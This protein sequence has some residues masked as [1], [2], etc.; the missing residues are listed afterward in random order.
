MPLMLLTQA[1]LE[2]GKSS[3]GSWSAKQLA[4]F[5]VDYN[6]MSKGWIRSIINREYSESVIIEFLALKD[7]HLKRKK[8][9]DQLSFGFINTQDKKI[10]KKAEK[11][12][13][14]K[15]AC[16]SVSCDKIG[17]MDTIE[18]ITGCMVRCKFSYD[19]AS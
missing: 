6:R 7:E 16:E 8:K 18:D 14:Y 3:R 17:N 5:G 11:L 19:Y 9:Q 10:N 2:K 13:R 12:R 1:I 4:L 15:S